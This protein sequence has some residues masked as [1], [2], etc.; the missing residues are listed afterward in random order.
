M[1]K[2]TKWVSDLTLRIGPIQTTGALTGVR[3]SKQKAKKPSFRYVTPEGKAVQQRYVDDEDTQYTVDQLGKA[4][5]VTD[6]EGNETLVPVAAEAIAKAK[7]SSLP[8]NI[9]NLTVH[10]AAQV[11]RELYQSEANGYV[12]TPNEDDP[13]NVAWHDLLIRLVADKSN[14]YISK[15]NVRGN[16]GL[17]RLTTWNG[18]LVLQRVLYPAEVNEYADVDLNP[19]ASET[20][21]KFEQWVTTQ[22]VPFDPNEY[23]DNV[24][25]N[26]AAMQEAFASG[27]E[28]YDPAPVAVE[29]VEVDLLA[30]L[31]AFEV[32]S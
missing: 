26:L 8:K 16:E 19:V 5:V 10:P 29:T 14:A 21:E 30:A 3:K 2:I 31:D 27:D 9:V 6:D 25:A 7:E 4:T 11:N 15:A 12:F 23:E 28:T 18:R 1:A 24:A 17:Y 13:A 32:T 22:T 20:V